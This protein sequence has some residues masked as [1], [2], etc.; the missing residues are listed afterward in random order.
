MREGASL[1]KIA[2]E[3]DTAVSLVIGSCV[4]IGRTRQSTINA[5]SWIQSDRV[6]RPTS[7]DGKTRW[8]PPYLI[9]YQ[10]PADKVM[11]LEGNS[12][13]MQVQVILRIALTYRK[14]WSGI[15][16]KKP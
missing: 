8:R 9:G 6:T 13:G 15:D 10:F 2:H 3:S 4:R 12:G 1:T 16:D 5:Q 11:L 7:S 14:E